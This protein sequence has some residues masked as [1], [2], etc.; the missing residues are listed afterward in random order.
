[1][2]L[3]QV[4][5]MEKQANIALN[6]FKRDIVSTIAAMAMEGVQPMDSL[7]GVGV[8]FGTILQT[9]GKLSPETY[10]PLEQAKAVEKA[11]SFCSTILKLD[12]LIDRKKVIVGGNTIT[13]NH[14]TVAV[15]RNSIADLDAEV[16]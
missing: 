2:T 5:E 16:A 7:N 9:G 10:L 15:L 13:L 1:M 11:L 14:K 8:D 6:K 4:F 3:N 12:E